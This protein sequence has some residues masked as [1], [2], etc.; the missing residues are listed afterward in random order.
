M[1]RLVAGRG[2]QVKDTMPLLRVEQE[3]DD[4]R[5]LVLR[6]QFSPAVGACAG[7]IPLRNDPAVLEKP[8]GTKFHALVAELR[9]HF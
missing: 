2:A 1:R 4:L 9:F 6:D 3:R 8:A 7:D 5:S